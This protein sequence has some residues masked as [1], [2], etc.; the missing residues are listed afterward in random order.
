MYSPPCTGYMIAILV[1]T[2]EIN[3]CIR[4]WYDDC[5]SLKLITVVSTYGGLWSLWI[6][7]M[8]DFDHT[9]ILHAAFDHDGISFAGQ[10]SPFEG[11]LY[12]L[13]HI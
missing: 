10:Y 11:I 6:F 2:T 3:G 1:V 4:C 7:I 13:A 5:G 9:C 12:Y 8:M